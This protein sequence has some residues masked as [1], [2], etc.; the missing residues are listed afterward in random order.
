MR[1]G[2][3]LLAP[4]IPWYAY[5]LASTR[6]LAWCNTLLG[7]CYLNSM[8]QRLSLFN[9]L[10]GSSLWVGSGAQARGA[11]GHSGPLDCIQPIPLHTQAPTTVVRAHRL[12]GALWFLGGVF[13]CGCAS[14]PTPGGPAMGIVTQ[15]AIRL[16]TSDFYGPS[17]PTPN[18]Q[19]PHDRPPPPNIRLVDKWKMGKYGTSE[20]VQHGG[21]HSTPP[22]PPACFES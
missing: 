21:K 6:H 2:W 18:T 13:P 4:P 22:P 7:P 1:F 15:W 12:A 14:V 3:R 19:A 16:Q 20:N 17:P 5:R 10:R 11:G 9:S 8:T